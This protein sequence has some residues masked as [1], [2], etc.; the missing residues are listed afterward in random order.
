MKH[1]RQRRV[2]KESQSG[3]KESDFPSWDGVT[4]D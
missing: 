2:S 4:D 3:L 1:L